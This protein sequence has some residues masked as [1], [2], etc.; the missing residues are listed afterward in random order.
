M[1]LILDN[2]SKIQNPKS[3]MRWGRESAVLFFVLFVLGVSMAA[4]FGYPG[5]L[6]SADAIVRSGVANDLVQGAARGRQ[7]LIGSLRWAPLPTLLTMPFL[8]LP[9]LSLGP[10]AMC[11]VAAACYALLCA[12]LNSWWAA[13]RV[14]PAVRIPIL[15]ALYLSP[16]VRNEIMA[17]AGASLFVLLAVLSACFFIDW[18]ERHELRSLAYLSLIV[19]LG[20]IA[21]Y[22][23]VLL[24]LLFLVGI[25][26]RILLKERGDI[27]LFRRASSAPNSGAPVSDVPPTASGD[28]EKKLSVPFFLRRSSYAEGTLII[29]VTPALYLAAL[30]VMANWL[31]MKSPGFF[32]R[33]LPWG[34]WRAGSWTALL[35]DGCD[36]SAC[37]IPAAVA[38]AGWLGARV[39]LPEDA[40]RRVHMGRRLLAGAGA[41]FLAL[42]ALMA[43]IAPKSEMLDDARKVALVLERCDTSDR[44][45]V[46]GYSGY[47]LDYVATPRVRAMLFRTLSIYIAQVMRDTRGRRLY[48]AVPPETPEYRWEDVHLKYP[49]LFGAYHSFVVFERHMDDW[50]LL[51][52]TRTD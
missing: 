34:D 44:V 39:F 49:H 19:G 14:S 33:G 46:S 15:L 38:L 22:Q 48:V 24:F 21:Q 20:I 3:E 28:G 26:A 8:R 32:L 52:V 18:W 13:L 42:V 43:P 23:F 47:A 31:I 4:F 17:G 25:F 35:S 51:G 45:A 9:G 40:T 37:V 29:Y 30:W 50:R 41:L 27:P 5:G 36:W 1:P 6:P 12:Y 11:V 2:Q 16:W 7:G 10:F